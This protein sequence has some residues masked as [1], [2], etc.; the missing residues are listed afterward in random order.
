MP[1]SP[2]HGARTFE[3]TSASLADINAAF[4]AGAL[5]SEGLR[6][7]ISR[8][9]MRTDKKGPRL[10]AVLSLNPRAM[11]EA[12]AL[13][14]ERRVKGPRGLLHGMPVLLKVQH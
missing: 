4:E 2:L 7:C 13:D 11:D 10:N 3:L 14:T 5:T 9:L 6:A 12:R 8:G 1:V